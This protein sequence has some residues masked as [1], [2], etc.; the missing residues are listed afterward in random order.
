M[1]D[2]LALLNDIWRVVVEDEVGQAQEE[3]VHILV[4]RV[5]TAL[6]HLC[7]FFF[8]R[9]IFRYEISV[10]VTFSLMMIYYHLYFHRL[11]YNTLLCTE[12][13]E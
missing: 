3:A 8:I 10:S 12:Y 13:K 6:L 5:T 9:L 2:Y 4:A 11:L 7:L 1:L